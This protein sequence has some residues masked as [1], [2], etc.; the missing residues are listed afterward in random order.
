M[1]SITTSG[2]FDNTR[3]L[4]ERAQKLDI[5]NVLRECGEQGV[6]A[7]RSG[8]PKDSGLAA[9]SWSYRVEQKGHIYSLSWHNTNLENG[10]PVALMI[11]YGHG[12]GTGGW[13]AGQD[14]INPAMKPVF[15]NITDRVWKAVTKA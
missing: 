8:T 7:L 13:V 12:T 9:S 15:D 1:F 14:Y 3:R 6:S 4:I 11:Q 5:L 10:Y 2:S